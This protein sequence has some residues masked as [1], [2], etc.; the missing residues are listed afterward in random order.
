MKVLLVS[1]NDLGDNGISTFIINNAKL[2]AGKPDVQIDVLAPNDVDS[3]IKED[4]V[5]SDVRVFRIPNRNSKQLEYFKNLVSLLKKRKYDVLHV[6]GSSTIMSIELAA[7]FFAGVKVRVA[8]SHNTV[9][10]HVGLNKALRPAFEMFVNQRLA[11]NEAAGKWLFKNKSFTV[12]DNGIFLDQ[13]QYNQDNRDKIRKSLGISPDT[14]LLGH[15][16][17]FNYQKNQAFLLKLLKKLPVNYK[18]VL[19]GQGQLFDEVKANSEELSLTDKVIFTG[20]VN[21]V[22]DYLS[23][24]DTFVLPSRFE[25]QPFVLIEAS[26][27]G[28]PIIASDKISKEV[29]LTGKI[30]FVPLKTESWLR[31]IKSLD[32]IDRVA[33]SYDNCERLASKGYDAVKNVDELY[34]FYLKGIKDE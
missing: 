18:L 27:N 30:K 7:G 5:A 8:H 17:G 13:Y 32:Q 12:I 10:E 23:A 20:S 28:L 29:N 15:V 26:A 19:I 6:N 25:G 21:N 9:T 31:S 3:K 22:P 16:G 24:M 11:C 1:T 4:L 14:I 34:N 33:E 2:L